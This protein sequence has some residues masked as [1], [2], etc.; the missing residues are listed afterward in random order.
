M[1]D[2]VADLTASIRDIP[3]FPKPG[4]LFKDITPILHDPALFQRVIDHFAERFAG[5]VDS[6]VGMESRGFLFGTPLALSLGVPFVLARKPGKLPYDSVGVEYA[7]EYGT[8]RLEMH[9]DSFKAG[10]RVLVVDDLLATGGTAN[11]TGQLIEKLGG[12]VA[13]YAFVIELGFLNGQSVL[14]GKPVESILV[15]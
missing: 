9:V 12:E 10:D 7:L 14:G 13:A 3:D 15:Y 4:I 6:V 1:A 8:N 5:H 11:A 2:L